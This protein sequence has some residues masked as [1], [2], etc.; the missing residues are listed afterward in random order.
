MALNLFKS[1]SFQ[2][3][4]SITYTKHLGGMYLLQFLLRFCIFINDMK[5]GNNPIKSYSNISTVI[6]NALLNI[7]E[8]SRQLKKNQVFGGKFSKLS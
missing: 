4:Y 5:T 1:L 6:K 2:N 7:K 8:V 3:T